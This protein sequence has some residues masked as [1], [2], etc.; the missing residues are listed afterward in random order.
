MRP[1]PHLKARQLHN[2]TRDST[3]LA[4]EHNL[5]GV[6]LLWISRYVVLERAVAPVLEIGI[7]S[8]DLEPRAAGV[9]ENSVGPALE[10]DCKLVSA[11]VAGVG[12]DPHV[13]ELGHVD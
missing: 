10:V 12:F 11:D 8:F 1:A 6:L 4:G 7:V 13:G 3:I 9:K 2:H 5:A